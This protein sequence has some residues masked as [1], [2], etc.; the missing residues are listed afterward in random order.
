MGAGVVRTGFWWGDMSERDY[1]E[2]LGVEG[3]VVLEWFISKS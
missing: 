2:E 3:S 1:L